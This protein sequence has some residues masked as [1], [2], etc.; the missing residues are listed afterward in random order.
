MFATAKRT[1]TTAERTF[2]TGERTFRSGE[3]KT[4]A[5]SYNMPIAFIAKTKRVF[6]EIQKYYSEIARSTVLRK[7]KGP[8]LEN[9][10]GY[11]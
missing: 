9:I 8:F 4:E 6:L 5:Y 1:F 3:H 2:A 11:P 7:H 10:K